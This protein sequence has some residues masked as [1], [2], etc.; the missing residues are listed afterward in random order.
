MIKRIVKM[1][2]EP[3]MLDDFFEA[4]KTVHPKIEAFPGC[5]GVK[6]MQ[7]EGQTNVLFTISHWDSNE[8]LQAYR[9]SDLFKTVWLKTKPKF[10]AKPEAWSLV[11]AKL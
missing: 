4:F 2:F 11:E 10:I 1:T 8:D 7:Q 6:L 9:N 5:N 3:A